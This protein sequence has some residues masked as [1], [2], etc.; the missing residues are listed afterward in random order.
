MRR[1]N[2]FYVSIQVKTPQLW[3]RAWQI[4]S[5]ENWRYANK[6]KNV[7]EDKISIKIFLVNNSNDHGGEADPSQHMLPGETHTTK[8]GDTDLLEKFEAEQKNLK[9]FDTT[10]GEAALRT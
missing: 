9:S 1:A 5:T 3:S 2:K 8:N 10:I 4:S 6:K 7:L